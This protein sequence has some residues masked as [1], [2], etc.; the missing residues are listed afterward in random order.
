MFLVFFVKVL[1]STAIPLSRISTAHAIAGGAPDLG[2][3]PGQAA[4]ETAAIISRI[5]VASNSII[6]FLSSELSKLGH[7]KTTL[8]LA[9]F[10]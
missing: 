6:F 5:G 4:A 1:T 8:K 7:R 10:D 3:T 9:A 2:T